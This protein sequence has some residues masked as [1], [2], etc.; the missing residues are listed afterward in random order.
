ML[1]Q[2][3]YI[4]LIL[5]AILLFV[6][7]YYTLTSNIKY[8]TCTPVDPPKVGQSYGLTFTLPGEILQNKI[9]QTICGY[10]TVTQEQDGVT[11]GRFI[12]KA[13]VTYT[14]KS[15]KSPD[16]E[17]YPTADD[18]TTFNQFTYNE[19]DCTLN[20]ALSDSL[21]EEMSRLSI[22]LPPTGKLT[23]DG[24]LIKPE[25]NVLNQTINPL[26]TAHPLSQ[27]DLDNLCAFPDNC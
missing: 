12:V 9:A 24:I 3:M 17:T 11:P 18:D 5:L 23:S 7:Y 1:R 22:T 13:V 4:I 20:F 8:N 26:L 19:C 14:D 10:L 21:I 2:I 25:I 15:G 16:C 6:Y 27:D